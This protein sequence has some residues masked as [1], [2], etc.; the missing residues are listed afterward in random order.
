MRRPTFTTLLISMIAG[1]TLLAAFDAR[2]VLSVNEPW[3]RVA[4]DGRSA[5]AFMNLRSSEPVTLV[6]VDSFAAR[7]VTLRTGDNRVAKS[8]ALPAN[9]PVEL[10]PDESRIRLTGLVRRIRMGEFVPLTLFVRDAQGN[11]QPLFVNAEV[12]KRSPT[13]DEMT[14]HDHSHDGHSHAKP[15][16]P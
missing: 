3:V 12:R 14:G 11:E 16:P 2:A 5:D 9:A 1:V 7:A 8:L 6:A 10:K 4:P 15:N 13:E